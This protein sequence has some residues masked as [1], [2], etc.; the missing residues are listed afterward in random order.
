MNGFLLAGASDGGTQPTQF[1]VKLRDLF[2]HL[3]LFGGGH[4]VV[5]RV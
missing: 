3:D 4:E 5:D 2:S 1:S